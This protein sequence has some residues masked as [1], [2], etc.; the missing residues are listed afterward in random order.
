[1]KRLRRFLH[2]LRA[3]FSGRRADF[4][5]AEE[6]ESHIR[7]QA[8]DNLR[9]GMTPEEAHRAAVLKFGALEA[10]KETYRDQRSLAPFETL[11]T[12]C[13]FALRMLLKSRTFSAVAI[14]MLAVGIGVNVAVF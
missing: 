1:M 5:I 11:R 8:D 13:R 6:F 14:L 2:R 10:V 7:M 12:D 9:A 4:E 3:A